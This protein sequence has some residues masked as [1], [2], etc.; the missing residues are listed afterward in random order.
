MVAVTTFLFTDI[1]GSTRL[2]EQ[3]PQEMSAT[4]ARHDTLS[5]EAVLKHHGVVVKMSGDGVHAAFAE[6]LDAVYAAVAIQRALTAA[7]GL[8]IR[9]RSGI[10]LGPAEQRDNDYFGTTVNR[11][12]RLANAANGGQIVLSDAVVQAIAAALPEPLAIR[13]L[14]E[15][16][17][18]DLTQAEPIYQLLH[19]ALPADF[20][21][22]RSLATNPNNLPNLLTSFVGRYQDL[23]AIDRL[24]AR[25]RLVAL[26]G[27]GG[28]GKTR[29]ALQ[30]AAFMLD[31]YEDGVWLVEL[32]S[33]RDPLVLPQAVA[34]VLGVDERAGV[35]LQD[36]LLEH[37]KSRHLLLVLDNCEHLI[38]ACAQFADTLLRAAPQLNILATSRE[39]LEIDGEAVY[40]VPAL[41]LPDP[42]FASGARALREI[43][44]ARLFLERAALQCPDFVLDD[45]TAPL[46]ARVCYRLDG[47]PLALE[48]AA[49][50]M[51]GMSLDEISAGLD[52]RF[53]FLTTGSRVALPRQKTLK[54][55][56]DWS[57]DLLSEEEKTL[58]ARLSVFVGGCFLSAAHEVCADAPEPVDRFAPRLKSLVDK[59]L[60]QVQEFDG[61]MR[62]GFL[63]TL[64]QYAA[65][66][67]TES[68]QAEV[69]RGRHAAC[70]LA[71]ARAAV[72]RLAGSAPASL[73]ER[74]ERE[75]DNFRAVFA[76]FQEQ[77]Q[78]ADD[79]VA[80]A[81][82]LAHYW[83]LGGLGR[84][85]RRVLAL[86]LAAGSGTAGTPAERAT[87]H[88]G[89][90]VLA[91]LQADLG[92]A[93]E[94]GS[95]SVECYRV[96][97]DAQGASKSMTIIAYATY[98]RDGYL[99][100]LALY[101]HAIADC[102]VCDNDRALGVVL[103]NLAHNA[104]HA[105][106]RDSAQDA[107]Q[108]AVAVLKRSPESRAGSNVLM[109][110]GLCA[111]Y[112]GDNAAALAAFI[113]HVKLNRETGEAQ[114]EGVALFYL[115]RALDKLDRAA[116]AL[117]NYL[118]ALRLLHERHLTLE[119]LNG[120]ECFAEMLATRGYPLA[121]CV[122]CA[123]TEAERARI[124][125][126]AGDQARNMRTAALAPVRAALDAAAIE[127]ASAS[128]RSL[129]IDQ[130]VTHAS[131]VTLAED[132]RH[133]RW[134]DPF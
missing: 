13:N 78:A 42:D 36:A 103:T 134:P 53:G 69:L 115:A 84:E 51:R 4:V 3:H 16:R 92:V 119:L 106:D 62:Y 31:R 132:G 131:R 49:A 39:G 113:D 68:G 9:V 107:M 86:A 43:E 121:A 123:A 82:T 21:P 124:G 74:L 95:K 55:M 61:E 19:P 12:A 23:L 133:L 15:L 98:V 41:P 129:T 17:L 33:L 94:Q 54:A 28:I 52:D 72:G 63:E 112:D 70:M 122:V 71:L 32:A 105:G 85:G 47:I 20:P 57:F 99:A 96:A 77:P 5:R 6:P 93:I 108:R 2:W 110:R 56:I 24:F 87:A 11:A 116:E 37:L 35:S 59:S 14:G 25:A 7:S 125:I 10:H 65:E 88:Y 48:L 46:L 91:Y 50:R 76:W 126:H 8:V 111:M 44:S 18:R 130:V 64:R 22:L 26:L 120:L 89:A 97:G 117:E 1:E 60:V 114:R 79:F 109:Y 30:S 34:K 102:E 67:L 128:G 45:A 118:Q 40:M 81:A 80:L 58:F 29:L 90:A 66:R 104:L 38:D 73:M 27:T 83:Q 75:Q 101:R 100:S 127:R